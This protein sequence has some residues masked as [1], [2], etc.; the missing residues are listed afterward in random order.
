MNARTHT[1]HIH[2]MVVNTLLG[3]HLQRLS[4]PSS[5]RCSA[6]DIQRYQ[7]SNN[8]NKNQHHFAGLDHVYVQVSA[9]IYSMRTG[10][11]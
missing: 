8:Y 4:A 9:C 1:L 5:N 2:Q 10:L 11:L 6:I 3:D 7:P